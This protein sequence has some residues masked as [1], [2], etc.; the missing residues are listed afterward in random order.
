V[1][2]HRAYVEELRE[3]GRLRPHPCQRQS[4]VAPAPSA[5]GASAAGSPPA[6]PAAEGIARVLAASRARPRVRPLRHEL[7]AALTASDT[8][9]SAP[10]APNIA[11]TRA[12]AAYPAASEEKCHF[13]SRKIRGV[14]AAPARSRP[15]P[16]PPLPA[17]CSFDV[18]HE[19]SIARVVRL[20]LKR[21]R[22]QGRGGLPVWLVCRIANR[23]LS[24]YPSAFER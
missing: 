2:E 14:S 21:R 22:G 4:S 20:E 17:H 3:R 13:L 12:S 18:R 16:A 1:R 10:S 8:N 9:A 5:A 23:A 15:T 7:E 6:C 24:R 19:H 11:G